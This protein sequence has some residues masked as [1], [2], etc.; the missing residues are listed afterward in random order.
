MSVLLLRY[1]LVSGVFGPITV[2]ETWNM[3]IKTHYMNGLTPMILKDLREAQT[4]CLPRSIVELA[5]I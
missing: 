5:A 3:Q 1:V 2:T 4:P